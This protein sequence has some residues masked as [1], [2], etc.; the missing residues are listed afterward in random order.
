MILLVSF[1]SCLCG[2]S[3]SWPCEWQGELRLINVSKQYPKL[4]AFP[5]SLKTHLFT[6]HISILVILRLQQKQDRKNQI[7]S[8]QRG[9]KISSSCALQ[10]SKEALSLCVCACVILE[11]LSCNWECLRHPVILMYL[12]IHFGTW[13]KLC[14]WKSHSQSPSFESIIGKLKM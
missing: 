7:Q 13:R 14:L 10:N 4:L 5:L 11:L 12:L 6:Q 8:K 1:F 9:R 3:G 2:H